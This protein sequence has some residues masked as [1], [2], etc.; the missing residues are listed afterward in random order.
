MRLYATF[1][2]KNDIQR[3]IC[4]MAS[5][6]GNSIA[7]Y[8]MKHLSLVFNSFEFLMVLARSLWH[9]SDHLGEKKNTLT[10]LKIIHQRYILGKVNFFPLSS[11]TFSPF[12]FFTSRSL[13]LTLFRGRGPDPEASTLPTWSVTMCSFNYI[14]AEVMIC[15]TL[16]SDKQPL[17]ERSNLIQNGF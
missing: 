7:L 3:N 17:P 5:F 4:C 1:I 10:F 14:Q 8:T 2:P 13:F 6:P 15:F 9:L 12:A 11:V 16:F